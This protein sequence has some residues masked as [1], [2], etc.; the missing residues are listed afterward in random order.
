MALTEEQR[1]RLEDL[2]DRKATGR[3]SK[4]VAVPDCIHMK[5]AHFMGIGGKVPCACTPDCID[6]P[7]GL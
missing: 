5:H 7:K 2:Q 3:L 6:C 1:N 4:P